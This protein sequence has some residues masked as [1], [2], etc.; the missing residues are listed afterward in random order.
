MLDYRKNGLSS[1][2]KDKTLESLCKLPCNPIVSMLIFD[3]IGKLFAYLWKFQ[4]LPVASEVPIAS[5]VMV[6]GH[7]M[8]KKQG[9]NHFP[10]C[11]ASGSVQ[12]LE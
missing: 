1:Y 5:G 4:E 6:C 8:I 9:T 2:T 10:N 7:N 12:F 11:Q 3:S